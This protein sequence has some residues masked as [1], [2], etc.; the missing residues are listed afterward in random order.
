M[1]RWG[2]NLPAA[3]GGRGGPR[4]VGFRHQFDGEGTDP[5]LH[6]LRL[7]L[8]V[9][10]A[11]QRGARQVI[12]RLGKLGECQRGKARRRHRRRHAKLA[13]GLVYDL[14]DGDRA[15][16]K[17]VKRLGVAA[18]RV[19][20]Q[21]GSFRRQPS[22]DLQAPQRPVA[23]AAAGSRIFACG[24]PAPSRDAGGFLGDVIGGHRLARARE[25]PELLVQ[26]QRPGEAV[27]EELVVPHRRAEHIRRRQRGKHAR[28]GRALGVE[29]DDRDA[30]RDPCR[31]AGKHPPGPDLEEQV[32]VRR[33]ARHGIAEADRLEHLPDEQVPQ[34]R[35]SGQRVPGH[36]G[37][38][39]ARQ[40]LELLARQ[41]GAE[42]GGGRR[43]RGGVER[44]RDSDLDSRDAP[45]RGER[46]NPLDGLDRARHDG[47]TGSV[48]A[49]DDDLFAR[50]QRLDI[51]RPGDDAGHRA[52]TV[53]G[54]P[55]DPAALGGEA[56]QSGFVHGPGPVQ[57]GQLAETVTGR[58][59]RLDAEQG[60]HPQARDRRGD[61]AWL[62]HGR[63]DE[64]TGG[65]GA[66]VR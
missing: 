29:R 37:K 25:E 36:R 45:V 61:D 33:H 63:G 56:E 40:R 42:L 41:V 19:E 26:R 28:Q 10:V 52:V 22:Q 66:A 60:K 50:E 49:G 59:H 13:R 32:D 34:V 46:A 1:A 27:A 14:P 30:G 3:V 16:V 47:L 51:L 12:E 58:R 5:G 48:V 4:A 24:G 17:L 35:I 20:W 62:G 53:A 18:H 55:H 39:A 31:E 7:P 11:G 2:E 43:H 64:I 15:E 54:L 8:R 38:Y 21:L 9:R 23:R 65:R 57:A 6:A 44:V